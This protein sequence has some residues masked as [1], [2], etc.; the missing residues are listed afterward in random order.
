MGPPAFPAGTPQDGPAGWWKTWARDTL[1][2]YRGF[3]P[4]HGNRCNI[5]FADASVRSFTD[6]NGD[7]LLNNGFPATTSNGFSDSRIELPPTEVFGGW[8]IK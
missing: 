4:V 8:S 3:A 5:V 6:V 7:G 2:D 1:Q